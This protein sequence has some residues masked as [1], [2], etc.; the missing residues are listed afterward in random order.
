MLLQFALLALDRGRGG[1]VRENVAWSRE[2]ILVSWAEGGVHRDERKKGRR[3]EGKKNESEMKV[4]SRRT[5]N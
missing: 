2:Q 3:K 1:R 4:K 5:L